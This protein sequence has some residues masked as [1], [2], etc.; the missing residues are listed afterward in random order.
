MARNTSVSLGDHFA[1]F[2]DQQ[3]ASGVQRGRDAGDIRPGY[4]KFAYVSHVV[5]YRQI[6]GDMDLGRVLH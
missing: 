5:F 6:D 1:A 3:V 2:V 4:F